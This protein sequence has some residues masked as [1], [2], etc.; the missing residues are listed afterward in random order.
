VEVLVTL[1]WFKTLK[2]KF[3]WRQKKEGEGERERYE[4]SRQFDIQYNCLST[5]LFEAITFQTFLVGG[6]FVVWALWEYLLDFGF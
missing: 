4:A 1:G 2:N 6:F 3:I 5:V